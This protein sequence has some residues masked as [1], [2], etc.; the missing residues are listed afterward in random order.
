MSLSVRLANT[1]QLVE[2]R[3]FLVCSFCS[4]LFICWLIFAKA[5]ST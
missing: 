1:S 3:C 2:K 4:V 5:E